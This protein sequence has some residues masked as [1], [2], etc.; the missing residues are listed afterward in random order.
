MKAF[1]PLTQRYTNLPL[2]H[3]HLLQ[4]L[5]LV[6]GFTLLW[7]MVQ[8]LILTFAEHNRPFLWRFVIQTAECL[9]VFVLLRNTFQPGTASASFERKMLLAAWLILAGWL[10]LCLP[11]GFSHR[12]P[13][14]YAQ[15]NLLF[16]QDIAA[17]LPGL[18]TYFLMIWLLTGLG[19][20]MLLV[21]KEK[22]ANKDNGLLAAVFFLTCQ[23]VLLLVRMGPDLARAGRIGFNQVIYFLLG[24]GVGGF[25]LIPALR[26]RL[27]TW[28]RYPYLLL[29]IAITCLAS[30][31]VFGTALS[32][33]KAL[34]IVVGGVS[35]QPVE[36][37]KILFVLVMATLLERKSFLLQLPRGRAVMVTFGFVAFCFFLTLFIQRDLG[38]ILLLSL[39]LLAMFVIASRFWLLLPVS[40]TVTGLAVWLVLLTRQPNIVYQ[41]IMDFWEPLAYSGQLTR[42]LWAQGAG[43]FWGAGLGFSKAA[44]IP[45]I[46]SDYIFSAMVAEKG[47]IGGLALLLVLMLFCWRIAQLGQMVGRV[48]LRDGSIMLGIS[49]VIFFQGFLIIAG[50]MALIPLTG[51]TLPFVSA[52]GTSLVLNLAA[53]YLVLALLARNT[54]EV[55]A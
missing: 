9:W 19:G 49:L 29:I 34:W 43:G 50:N 31:F 27:L 32:G 54:E 22:F 2:R 15:A 30:T 11:L 39:T 6:V 16:Y 28:L 1:A 36:L 20:L 4:A 41:R 42:G 51:L 48:N 55:S 40:L 25:L 8:F 45:I 47:F 12:D 5:L 37:A 10:L 38:P 44:T 17:W 53:V 18:K 24:A 7:Q 3:R 23:S 52:G 46:E 13:L 33:G 14:Q 26:E 21:W 35:F